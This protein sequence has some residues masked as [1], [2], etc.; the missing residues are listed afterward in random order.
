MYLATY[1]QR[2]LCVFGLG[3]MLSACGGTTDPPAATTY[4]DV[5]TQMKSA[6]GTCHNTGGVGAK[7]FIIDATSSANTYANLMTNKFITTA[8]PD[9]SPLILVGKGGNY[10]PMAGGAAVPHS[11]NLTDAMATTWISWITAGAAQ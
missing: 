1:A 10:V 2:L 11:K 4:A 3:M 8:T 5:Y 6:C 9:Q 7:R